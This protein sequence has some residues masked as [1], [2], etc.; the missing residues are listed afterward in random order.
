MHTRTHDS[1][2]K[3][4]S[5]FTNSL[6]TL[7]STQQQTVAD[8][9]SSSTQLTALRSSFCEVCRRIRAHSTLPFA[10]AHDM[11]IIT[12]LKNSQFTETHAVIDNNI[13]ASPKDI[14]VQLSTLLPLTIECAIGLIVGGTLQMLLLLL[15]F[16][17]STLQSTQNS[18]VDSSERGSLL[19]AEVSNIR[20]CNV[21]FNNHIVNIQ[22]SQSIIIKTK[23]QQTFLPEGHMKPTLTVSCGRRCYKMFTQSQCGLVKHIIQSIFISK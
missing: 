17:I 3:Y 6:V 8:L 14:S 4:L 20:L 7:I 11:H 1:E 13:Q 22:L 5:I 9:S 12:N 15:L 10:A 2:M 16:T 21:T 23:D 18:S 19:L